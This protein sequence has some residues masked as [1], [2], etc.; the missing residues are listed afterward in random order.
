ML[1]YLAAFLLF[2]S[3]NAS[4]EPPAFK[5]DQTGLYLKNYTTDGLKKMFND[6]GYDSYID[7]PNDEYPRIFVQNIPSDF[8]LFE[9][10]TLRNRYFMQILIPLILKVNEEIS[11]EREMLE[12]LEYHFEQNKDFDDM[13]MYFLDQLASKYDVFTHFKDTRKYIYIINELKEKIDIIPPS[14]VI[15]SA[16]VHTDWGTSRIA[17]KA[18]NLFKLRLW[19]TNEGLE[20]LEDQKEGYRYEIFNNL[21]ESIKAYALKLNSNVNYKTFRQ[22]RAV[23]RKR[24]GVLY[25]KRMDFSLVLDS[26]LTNY[27][28]L[29]DY[30]LTYYKLHYI[31]R[32]HLEDEHQFKD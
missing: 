6:L 7:L 14:I 16:A 21:E 1:K 26:N 28:G 10:K 24:G 19:Y 22:A 12:A 4:A 29:I 3:F 15:A 11:Q 23:A 5:I 8:A 30:T 20:P 27:A 9:D 2:F 18:N 31:D 32:A 13:D 25:G 17:I